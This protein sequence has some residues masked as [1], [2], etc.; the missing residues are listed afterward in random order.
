MGTVAVC[1]RFRPLCDRHR[2]AKPRNLGR[3]R[4]RPA[5]ISWRARGRAFVC[6]GDR[7]RRTV[8]HIMTANPDASCC[9]G[10]AAVLRGARAVARRASCCAGPASA[11]RRTGR[12]CSARAQQLARRATPRPARRRALAWRNSSRA[13]QHRGTPRSDRSRG[14]TARPA[15]RRALVRRNSSRTCCCSA[16]RCQH[17]RVPADTPA[18][19]WPHRDVARPA[20]GRPAHDGP[21][22][23]PAWTGCAE[24]LAAPALLL[25]ARANMLAAGLAAMFAML[26]GPTGGVAAS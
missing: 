14:A 26:G 9:S 17:V 11:R 16:R 6:A 24:L 13:E 22:A 10:R 19:V 8:V 2:V 25:G 5:E 15:Q 7:A 20:G 4:R 23:W 1:G 18:G 12:C 21:I 3:S